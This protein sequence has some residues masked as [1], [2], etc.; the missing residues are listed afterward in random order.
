MFC[1][2]S[3]LNHELWRHASLRASDGGILA[4]I[5]GSGTE[6]E[7]KRGRDAAFTGRLGSPPPPRRFMGRVLAWRVA[8][9]HT[10]ESMAVHFW[11]I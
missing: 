7:A 5:S 1:G 8:G 10:M 9:I 3:S 6:I 11:G 2:P 4:A